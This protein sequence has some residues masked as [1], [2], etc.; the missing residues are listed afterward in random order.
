MYTG[1]FITPV[2][3][4]SHDHAKK[5]AKD[6]APTERNLLIRSSIH[7][8]SYLRSRPGAAA[9]A[10]NPLSWTTWTPFYAQEQRLYSEA[11]P[12]D[13][14]SH[15]T[16]KGDPSHPAEKTYFNRLYPSPCSLDR[17]P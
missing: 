7:P 13:W 12:D 15:P 17:D 9:P 4:W 8:S 3:I 14:A 11:L 16:S 1:H 6:Y 10:K 5:A 2:L